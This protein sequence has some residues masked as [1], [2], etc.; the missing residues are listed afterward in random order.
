MKLFQH[1]FYS[2]GTTLSSYYVFAWLN[3]LPLLPFCIVLQSKCS[4]LMVEPIPNIH[5]DNKYIIYNIKKSVVVV[6]LSL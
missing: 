6:K 2:V 1:L 5:F 4:S 3:L